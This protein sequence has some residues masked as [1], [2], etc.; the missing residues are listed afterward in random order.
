MRFLATL[1]VLAL[2]LPN[3]VFAETRII[4]FPVQGTFSFRD[5]YGEPRGDGTRAH[6]GIDIVAAKMTPLVAAVDGTVTFVAIPQASWGYS[7]TIRD[8][9]GYTYRYLHMNNDTPGTDD[10][11]G[12]EAHA[13]APEIRRGAT[14]TRG[15]LI[16]WVGDSGNAESTVSHLH[17]EIRS[18]NGNINPYDSLYA[19]AGG[20]GSGTFVE[21]V[22]VGDTGSI[23]AEE[24]FVVTRQLQEGMI[25]RDVAGLHQELTT[26][27]YYSGA[28]T[29]TFT[30]ATREA[31]RAFQVAQGIRATGIADA[32]TRKAI[33][34]VL[35][36]PRFVPTSS[37]SSSL[38][39][40]SSGERVREVQL[41]LKE[42]GYFTANA[43]GYFGPIT[44]TAVI[45]FQKAQ[46]IDP[47]GVVGPKTMAALATSDVDRAIV[48]VTVGGQ[49]VFS[50][51][52][53]LGSRGAA[54]TELQKLLATLGHFSAEPTGYFGS[55]TH[56]SV[57]AFQ[58]EQGI[59]PVGTVG[60]KTRAALNAAREVGG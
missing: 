9:A 25:D 52:L 22:V 39:L 46:G 30:T 59:D 3:A 27:G 32:E 5:D 2:L 4:T 35:K 16:G 43:T 8:S 26:L 15:Q 49:Y 1:L 20:N 18:P 42:L 24:A 48:E 7:V 44:Q 38:S 28:I 33:Q 19:A 6:E 51:T 14:V 23:E 53:D 17:F 60:P 47:I 29:E 31:V 11:A 58:K 45:A 37:T 55:I 21:P 50:T 40:G 10:G 54:V 12:G 41:R 13:Y 57:V 56:A 34:R 36:E